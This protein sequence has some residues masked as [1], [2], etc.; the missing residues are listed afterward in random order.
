MYCSF[1]VEWLLLLHAVHHIALV[2]TRKQLAIWQTENEHLPICAVVYHALH[3]DIKASVECM[4]EKLSL[5]KT[6]GHLKWQY[7]DE[8][9]YNI[10]VDGDDVWQDMIVEYRYMLKSKFISL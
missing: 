6:I 5:D 2:H 7:N 9:I 4:L 10:R 1:P 8:P 3:D